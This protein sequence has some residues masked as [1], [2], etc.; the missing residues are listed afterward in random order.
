MTRCLALAIA[1]AACS[2]AQVPDDPSD[3]DPTPDA[4][5]EPDPDPAAPPVINEVM[6]KPPDDAVTGT[7]KH[8]FIEI[9]GAANTDY[10]RYAVI[11]IRGQGDPGEPGQIRTVHV[12]GSTDAAGLWA[13]GYLED[14]LKNNTE[15]FL[16]VE[17]FTG[18]EGDDLDTDDDGV[19][20]VQPW[21]RIVDGVALEDDSAEGPTHLKYTSVVLTPGLD[22]NPDEFEG[23]SRR[24]D[25][26]DTDSAADW[27]RNDP[28]GAGLPEFAG[29]PA[30]G[31]ALSTM[32][33]PNQLVPGVVAGAKLNEFVFNH[34]GPD[35]C[36]YVEVK[37][38]PSTNLSNLTLVV[39]EGDVGAGVIDVAI[40][41]GTTDAAG[42]FVTS[43]MANVFE[44]G[45]QTLLLVDGFTGAVGMDL[46]TD[47]DGTL[48]I[49][50]WIAILDAVAI[51]DADA[52]DRTYAG[53]AV[54]TPGFDGGTNTVGGASRIADGVDTDTAADWARNDFDGEGLPFGTAGTATAGEARNTPGAPNVKL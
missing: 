38:E 41:L 42:F 52:A 8:E 43:M 26:V 51:Q 32:G 12:I 1:L 25:G 15:T 34:V 54:L 44:N 35:T 11:Q 37:G 24:V 46:D 2:N 17:G 40:P 53:A 27:V 4:P 19:L 5:V 45:S 36:E 47:D 23:A 10:S 22:G 29:S 39:I 6:R 20:D 9:H 16:L 18:A 49:Q 7:E 30:P 50:P 31:E 13:T 3:P 28:D 21:T 48:D 33:L 14:Q